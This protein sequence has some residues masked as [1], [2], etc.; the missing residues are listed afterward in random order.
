MKRESAAG[1]YAVLEMG[2]KGETAEKG[3]NGEMG[4]IPR[5]K[6]QSLYRHRL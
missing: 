1:D 4:F 6:S 5:R 2:E 3:D